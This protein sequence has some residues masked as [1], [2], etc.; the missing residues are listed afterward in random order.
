MMLASYSR[1]NFTILRDRD[2]LPAPPYICS[3]GSHL[4]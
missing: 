4:T 1:E 3:T 2:R